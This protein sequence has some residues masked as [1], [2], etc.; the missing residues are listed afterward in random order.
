MKSIKPFVYESIKYH[1][2]NVYDYKV[3]IISR[4]V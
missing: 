2:R 3:L 1:W 4:G